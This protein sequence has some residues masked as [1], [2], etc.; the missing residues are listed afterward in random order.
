MILAGN[1]FSFG[2]MS[3]DD[4]RR[5]TGIHSEQGVV[6]A[7]LVLG[8]VKRVGHLSDVVVEGARTDEKRVGTDGLCRLCCEVRDLHG[9]LE[10]AGGFLCEGM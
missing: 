8:I 6:G 5:I 2:H 10:S 9:V 1:A 7:I 4:L 3:D